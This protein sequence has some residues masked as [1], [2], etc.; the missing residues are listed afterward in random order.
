[1]YILLS[2]NTD[3]CRER[4]KSTNIV[5]SVHCAVMRERGLSQI[6]TPASIIMY[7]CVR[8]VSSREHVAYTIYLFYGHAVPSLIHTLRFILYNKILITSVFLKRTR[9]RTPLRTWRVCKGHNFELA[10]HSFCKK[11]KTIRVSETRLYSERI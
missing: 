9:L 8:I 4:D 2:L 11:N 1:M 7:D 10:V 5:L 6:P 3:S